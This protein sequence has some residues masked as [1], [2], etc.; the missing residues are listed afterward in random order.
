MLVEVE[1]VGVM[2]KLESVELFGG[3]GFVMLGEMFV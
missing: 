3:K 1:M 2:R